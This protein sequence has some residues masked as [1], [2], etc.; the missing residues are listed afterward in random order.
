MYYTIYLNDTQEVT[1]KLNKDTIIDL[2]NKLNEEDEEIVKNILSKKEYENLCIDTEAHITNV[3]VHGTDLNDLVPDML[4]DSDINL[5]IDNTD[6]PDLDKNELK[7]YI[8]KLDSVLYLKKQ[9]L[10]N[11]E[12]ED[13]REYLASFL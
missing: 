3:E 5:E 2:T 12:I 6:G 1:L 9:R 13:L 11:K 10:T 7:E 8:H 4:E